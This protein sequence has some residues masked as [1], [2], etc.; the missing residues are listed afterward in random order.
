M[1]RLLELFAGTHSIGKAFAKAGWDVVSLDMDGNSDITCD[2]MDW[3]WTVYPPDHFDCV[4]ASPPCTMYSRART[5]AKTPRDME[6]SDRLVRR[7]LDCID[8]FAC[9]WFMEN[10]QTG[11]LKTRPVVQGL[12]FRDVSYCRYG[13]EYKKATRIWTNSQWAPLPMCSRANPCEQLREGVHPISAQR[14][15]AKVGGV[16]RATADD[17]CTLEQL[18]SMPE[19]LCDDIC[20]AATISLR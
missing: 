3:D 9:T 4:W 14:A 1:V 8:Y 5:R 10:P 12:P 2:F 6:G 13:F 16:R 18:Y 20:R 15:P 19:G 7:V 11:Y 17:K